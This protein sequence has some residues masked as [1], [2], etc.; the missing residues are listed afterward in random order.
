MRCLLQESIARWDDGVK[1]SD[2]L[3][4]VRPEVEVLLGVRRKKGCPTR[5]D[6][7]WGS[8]EWLGFVRV[9]TH[10]HE[11]AGVQDRLGWKCVE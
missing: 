6:L 1:D 5:A 11:K 4:S 2:D 3:S 8:T 9:V 10:D 7:L